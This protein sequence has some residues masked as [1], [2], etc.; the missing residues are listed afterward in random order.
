MTRLKELFSRENQ[1]PWLANLRRSWISTGELQNWIDNG[2]RGIT[3]NP[4]IFQKAMTDTDDYDTQLLQLI[5]SGKSIEESYWELVVEDI[6]NAL[7][8]LRP[9]YEESA[10]LDGFV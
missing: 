2:V 5:A 10:G 1:S 6:N 9:L 8:M 3:S 4:T 7:D